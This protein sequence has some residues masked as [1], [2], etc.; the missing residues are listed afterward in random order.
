MVKLQE[1]LLCFQTKS[2]CRSEPHNVA[3]LLFRRGG[4]A[5]VTVRRDQM[6]EVVHVL[7]R[8]SLFSFPASNRLS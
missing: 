8:E 3:V 2:V 1:R 5:G 4:R 7:S 6:S